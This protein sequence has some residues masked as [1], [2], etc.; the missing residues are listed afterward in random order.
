VESEVYQ[1]PFIDSR[2]EADVLRLH[3]AVSDL[4]VVQLPQALFEIPFGVVVGDDARW[5]KLHAVFDAVRVDQQVEE[6]TVGVVRHHSQL[7]QL[8]QQNDFFDALREGGGEIGVLEGSAFDRIQLLPVVEF[9]HLGETTLE[10]VGDFVALAL[11]SAAEDGQTHAEDVILHAEQ[12]IL[13]VVGGLFEFDLQ[14]GG[15]LP[16]V[17]SHTVL[18]Q[19]LLPLVLLLHTLFFIQLSIQERIVFI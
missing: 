7:L 13:S 6:E 19:E 10:F 1:N 8:F 15:I 17:L 9:V 2:T 5:T 11:P 18:L 3:V 12:K 4:E 14:I 16:P